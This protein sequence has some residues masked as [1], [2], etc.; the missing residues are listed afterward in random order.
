VKVITNNDDDDDD[1]DVDDDVDDH[2]NTMTPVAP[3]TWTTLTL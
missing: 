1:D 2:D 3:I